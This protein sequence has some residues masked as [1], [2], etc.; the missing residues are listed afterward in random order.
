[1]K[2]G[3]NVRFLNAVGGGR[4]S[5]TD[6][7]QGIVYVEDEDG[8]EIPTLERDCVVVGEVNTN[9]NVLKKDFSA[10][11]SE[12]LPEKAAIESD[13][14]KLASE[15]EIQITETPEGDTLSAYL[16]FVPHNVKLLQTTACDFVLIN[17]S[18]YFLFY[19]IIIGEGDEKHSVA[20]GI[21]EPNIL[22]TLAVIQKDELNA[23]EKVGVQVVAFKKD[24]KYVPQK[25]IDT[26]I[27]L[28]TVKFYKLHSFEENDYFDEPAW[29]VD[30]V[31]AMDYRKLEKVSPEEIQDA[32]QTKQE[33]RARI[34]LKKKDNFKNNVLEIDL[35]INE[36]LDTTT[37]MSNA[38]MLNYQ[39]NHFHKIIAEN[40]KKKGQKIVFIHGKGD[41]VLRKEIENQL[42]TRYKSLYFQ[43]ASFREYGF[44]ATM[45]TI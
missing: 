39:L 36:L 29:L 21:L 41:G 33:K 16:A 35:H 3:D 13:F 2:I 5:R 18:N 31:K 30:I 1:M 40:E 34:V 6:S 26:V 12:D 25:A 32:I 22:E 8:F 9:T 14:V 4:I 10:K 38:D 7:K 42:K 27:S 11:Q 44:G 45:I 20:N 24:K 37:G 17:D 23:W 19:N 15:P 43:D 28:N